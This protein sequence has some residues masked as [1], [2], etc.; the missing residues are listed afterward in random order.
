MSLRSLRERPFAGARRGCSVVAVVG[1][2]V[3]LLLTA[4]KGIGAGG[5]AD[6]IRWE[7]SGHRAAGPQ[8][9]SCG[10]N[11]AASRRCTADYEAGELDYHML[12]Q[13]DKCSSIRA[14]VKEADDS[15]TLSPRAAR[16]RLLSI[17]SDGSARSLP[18]PAG[19]IAPN[20][21]LSE[22]ESPVGPERMRSCMP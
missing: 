14:R 12:V 4:G 21:S 20:R 8:I 1:I 9:V 13:A 22:P 17:R 7:S 5:L 2:G 10:K 16:V 18:W 6:A 11:P 19:G 15:P 3:Y